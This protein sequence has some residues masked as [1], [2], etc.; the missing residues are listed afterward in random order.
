L[1]STTERF[2]AFINSKICWCRWAVVSEA[3]VSN[4]VFRSNETYRA[5]DAEDV[6]SPEH[7]VDQSVVLLVHRLYRHR[8]NNHSS[9]RA[10]NM[11]ETCDVPTQTLP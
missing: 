5:F 8:G 10:N 9:L 1:S 2:V 4:I 11:T 3:R 6:H 7:V